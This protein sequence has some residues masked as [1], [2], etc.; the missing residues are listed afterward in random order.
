MYL[1]FAFNL[2]NEIFKEVQ[3]EDLKARAVHFGAGKE[4]QG[5]KWEVKQVGINQEEKTI[6]APLIQSLK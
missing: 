6:L 2:E 5:E 1:C 4:L 3:Q